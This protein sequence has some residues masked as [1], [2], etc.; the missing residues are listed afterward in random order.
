M[1]LGMETKFRAWDIAQSIW[2]YNSSMEYICVG[3]GII[4]I[5]TYAP[6]SGGGYEPQSLKQ[7]TWTE[8]KNLVF[9][10]FS[11]KQ[12][13]NGKEIYHKDI[14]KNGFDVKWLVEWDSEKLRWVGIRLDNSNII[15]PLCDLVNLEIIGN[16][17]ENPELL[18]GI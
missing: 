11:G 4:V 6:V 2:V 13:I 14:V 18:K 12:D 3:D 1:E 17:L 9:V 7:L 16:E 10:A 5:V 15:I 8:I